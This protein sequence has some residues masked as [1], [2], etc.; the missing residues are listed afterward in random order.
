MLKRIH[1]NQHVIKNNN[2]TGAR[3]A[4]LTVKSSASNIK[5]NKVDILDDNGIIIASVIYSPDKPLDCGAKCWIETKA[6]IKWS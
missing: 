1:V 5:C 3:E 2:K 4:P 6:Q